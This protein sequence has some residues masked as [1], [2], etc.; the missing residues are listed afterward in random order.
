MSKNSKHIEFWSPKSKHLN[1]VEKIK[2][3]F[4]GWVEKVEKYQN[5]IE[6][7]K[8]IDFWSRNVRQAGFWPRK[9]RPGY[10]CRIYQA[11]EDLAQNSELDQWHI[12]ENSEFNFLSLVFAG[13]C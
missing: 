3:I 2:T 11:Q 12:A 4:F 10:Q 1:W 13:I 9:L 5:S 8:H 6:K 7:S